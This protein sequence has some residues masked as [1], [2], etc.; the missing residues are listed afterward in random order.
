MG[1]KRMAEGVATGWL[2]QPRGDHGF[3]H[4]LLDDAFI[5]M[6]PPLQTGFSVSPA[7]LLGE[8]PLP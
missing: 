1:G 2:G 7:M 8:D 5:K 6:V 4:R 3:S